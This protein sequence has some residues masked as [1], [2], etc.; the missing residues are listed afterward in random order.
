MKKIL[1]LIV[2]VSPLIISAKTATA[3]CETAVAGAAVTMEDYY[4]GQ[5]TEAS[6]D[7][8]I[9]GIDIALDDYNKAEKPKIYDVPLSGELQAYTYVLCNVYGVELDL[10][11]SVMK[12]ESRFDPNA[13][14]V[15]SNGTK[16]YGLM[17]INSSNFNSLEEELGVTDFLNP[18]QNILSG[19]YMLSTC[20]TGD[21][22][23]TIL[24]RYNLGPGSARDKFRQGIFST[25]YSREIVGYMNDLRRVLW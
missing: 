16:D 9:A 6:Y 19:I 4:S 3:K 24:M 18:T 25:P 15:N 10:A 20:D 2:M 1:M 21:S 17:Q 5:A 22:V 12:K 14:G 8:S 7:V 11:L 23:H 13:I